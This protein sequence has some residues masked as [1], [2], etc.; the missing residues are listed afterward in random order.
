LI[1]DPT[2]G[3]VTTPPP[4]VREAIDSHRFGQLQVYVFPYDLARHIGI[5]D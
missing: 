1:V 4:I 2:N 3:F 5:S